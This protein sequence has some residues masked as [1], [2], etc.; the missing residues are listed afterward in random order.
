MTNRHV[1]ALFTV[2]LGRRG[3]R[4]TAGDAAIDFKRELTSA[5]DDRSAYIEVREVVMIHPYWDMALVRVEGLPAAHGVL[6]LSVNRPED[7]VNRDVVVVGYPALDPR[8]DIPLQNQ[9]FE[10]KYEVKRLQ[11]GKLR[12]RAS[13]RSFESTVSAATHDSSTLGGNSGSAVID[14]STGEVVAL[15]FAGQ[16]LKANYC[17]PTYEL[18]RDPRVVDAGVNFTGRVAAQRRLRCGLGADRGGV[19]TA[20]AAAAAPTSRPCTRRRRQNVDGP[21]SRDRF[22]SA[23]RHWPMSAAAVRCGAAPVAVAG[24]EAKMQVPVIYPDLESRDGYRPDFLDLPGGEVVPL[25]TLTSAG[26]SGRVQA[27]RRRPPN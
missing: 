16:Y 12:K 9:I 5:E 8:N 24:V 25:P 6:R 10:G 14:V 20:A 3:L 21:H 18:A 22:R 17:V 4:F 27:R 11:P 26:K 1:A 15:H 19:R 7:L 13:I 2:G 23:H